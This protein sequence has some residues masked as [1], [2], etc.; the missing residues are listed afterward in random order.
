MLKL[1]ISNQRGGVAKTTTTVTLARYLADRGH[2]VLVVDTDPQGSL[3][4]ILGL[5]AGDRNLHSFLVRR[6]ALQDCITQAGERIDV[7]CSDRETAKTEH[8]LYAE[9]ARELVFKS[10]FPPVESKYDAILFDVAPS[11]SLIQTCATIYAEQV[12]VPVTMDPLS[13]Q[14]AIAAVEAAQGL[15]DFFKCNIRTIAILPVVVD[16]RYQMTDLIM[17]SIEQMGERNGIAVL[18]HIRS[19]AAVTKASRMKQ[20]LQDFDP[21]GHAMCDYEAA[22]D[23]LLALVKDQLNDIQTE[24]SA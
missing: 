11:I 20:F 19:D 18:P 4:M 7:I 21:R 23:A 12:L 16:R 1:V 15:G 2:R 9:M 22:F 24:A 13:M 14:G 17:K 10:I 5:K 6:Y 3:G 8:I